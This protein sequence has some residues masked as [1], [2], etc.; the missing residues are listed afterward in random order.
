MIDAVDDA[1]LPAKLSAEPG[2]LVKRHGKKPQASGESCGA[3]CHRCGIAFSIDDISIAQQHN[4]LAREHVR[5]HTAINGTASEAVRKLVR[6]GWKCVSSRARRDGP[7]E[8][9]LRDEEHES[10]DELRAAREA[11]DVVLGS[12]ESCVVANAIE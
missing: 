12:G 8:A 5:Q 11:D 9:G 3:L 10:V 2:R 4:E 7:S 1:K 6:P